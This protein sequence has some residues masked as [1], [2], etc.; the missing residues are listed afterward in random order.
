[1]LFKLSKCVNPQLKLVPNK[2]LDF[3]ANTVVSFKKLLRYLEQS[4]NIYQTGAFFFLICKSKLAESLELKLFLHQQLS[5]D[6][7][8]FC[9]VSSGKI[10]LRKKNCPWNKSPQLHV[11]F[12]TGWFLCR[13]CET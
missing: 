7:S 5:L 10:N 1:M 3:L 9:F 13:P 2:T 4:S 12:V 6:V 8:N 11:T